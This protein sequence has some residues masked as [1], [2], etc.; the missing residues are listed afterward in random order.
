M[1]WD[2]SLVSDP[3]K[4]TALEE[5]TKAWCKGPWTSFGGMAPSVFFS[6]FL[7]SFFQIINPKVGWLKNMSV[8][9]RYLFIINFYCHFFY[10]TVFFIVSLK[11]A[12]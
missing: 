1:W 5:F 9:T 10:T 12:Y 7:G 4:H 8:F 2:L 11:C 6:Y 3:G